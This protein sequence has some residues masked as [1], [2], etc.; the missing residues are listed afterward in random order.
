MTN[1]QPPE[2]VPASAW[3]KIARQ[4]GNRWAIS[5]RDSNGEIIGT[6]YRDAKGDKGFKRGGRRGLILEW[7]MKPYTGTSIDAPIFVCEG[8]S[9]TA[10]MLGLDLDAVGRPMA[11]HA[12]S[13]AMLAEL[14]A[15]LH[16]VILSDADKTGRLSTGKVAD[17][18]TA[19]CASVRIVEPPLGAKDARAAVIAGADRSAFLDGARVAE[20]TKVKGKSGPEP[21]HA[22]GAP[23]LLRLSDVEPRNV[24]WLWEGRIPRGRISLLSGRPGEGK[25]MATMDWAARV[26]SGR[27]WPDG[28]PCA[29]GSVVLV[30][31]EDDPYDTIR[32]RLDAHGADPTRVHL[33][34]S[35]MHVGRGGVA[36][37]A[38]FT[39]ADLRALESTLAQIP[40]C[41]LVIVD[42]IGSF[43]GGAVDA[44]RDNEVRSILAP[45]AALAQ[46]SLAAVLLV[47]HQ[48]KGAAPHADDLVLGSRAFTGIARS[49]LHLLSDPD[50][51][52]RRLLLP[53]KINLARP[54][55]G[56]AF[57]IGSTPPRIEWEPDPVEL[58]ADGV[59]AA[60]ASASGG[61]HTKRDVAEV[62]LQDF[63]SEG[64]RPALKVIAEAKA[65]GLAERTVRRAMDGAGVKPRKTGV[66]GSWVWELK[67]NQGGKA[68][69]EDC[70]TPKGGNLGTKPDEPTEI[71]AKIAKRGEMATLGA[72]GGNLGDAIAGGGRGEE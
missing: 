69:P 31:G 13:R 16:V 43:I 3:A 57:T 27:D 64:P 1:L 34:Q 14:L 48:R 39:L 22:D 52:E 9:D 67:Q 26:T 59:L 20:P 36:R 46:R 66:R 18:I 24:L 10:A 42:P 63:L 37:E 8:A 19:R 23:V 62:W 32:P 51:E 5:E 61:R 60:Q 49:V 65:A 35:V 30:A 4:D 56:L 47:A 29:V 38:A 2:G 12:R 17:A 28:S 54:A 7:P 50:N 41:A 40:D 68:D 53:G 6:A 21:G 44:H 45:L 11:E 70:R 25:S 15:G 58:T 33:L 72:K 55:A 71:L